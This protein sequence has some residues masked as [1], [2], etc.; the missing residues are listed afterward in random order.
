M[1]DEPTVLARVVFQFKLALLIRTSRYRYLFLGLHS[2]PSVAH[3]SRFDSDSD[4]TS[5]H[6][7]ELGS[8]FGFGSDRMIVSKMHQNVTSSSVSRYFTL[9]LY[10]I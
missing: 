7:F 8:E 10:G 9:I 4:P 6:R 5:K 1:N 3:P 2:P